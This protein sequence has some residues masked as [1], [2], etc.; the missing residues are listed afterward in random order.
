MISKCIVNRNISSFPHFLSFFSPITVH[1]LVDVRALLIQLNLKLNL[2]NHFFTNFIALSEY[3]HAIKT[4]HSIVSKKHKHI[5][6]EMLKNSEKF[7]K[8]KKLTENEL[9]CLWMKDP[10]GGT[11]NRKNSE[12]DLFIYW[13]IK[14][15]KKKTFFF[16]KVNTL[17][18]SKICFWNCFFFVISW[19]EKIK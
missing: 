14:R 3:K 7:W 15:K 5:H 12:S 16:N 1:A 2:R 6:R 11:K 18:G 13:S 8:K 19:I 9:P 10:R 17:C 4:F